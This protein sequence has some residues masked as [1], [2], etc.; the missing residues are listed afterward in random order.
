MSRKDSKLARIT[1]LLE[2]ESKER[3]FVISELKSVHLESQRLQNENSK[4]LA[5]INHQET[6]L[7]NKI[8]ILLTEKEN[9]ERI[10][11]QF[12]K[13]NAILDKMVFNSKES[14]NREG[15][16]YN[17]NSHPKREVQTPKTPKVTNPKSSLTKCLYC[18][19][20]GHT[21]LYCK[22]KEDESKGKYKW[23]PK[24]EKPKKDKETKVAQK[25]PNMVKNIVKQPK[26]HYH[27]R[28]IGFQQRNIKIQASTSTNNTRHS[29][30]PKQGY[31]ARN[32]NGHGYTRNDNAY[33]MPRNTSHN[34]GRSSQ[35]GND[36]RNS[37]VRNNMN[38]L[39]ND[40]S[41]DSIITIFPRSNNNHA[42]GNSKYM[43]RRNPYHISNRNQTSRNNIFF[44]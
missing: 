14:F 19:V 23:I 16:G 42:S 36:S 1:S 11:R 3:E 20:S 8:N 6:F 5:Q 35:Y 27:Q 37:Y 41:R 32:P 4:I 26:F 22:A 9:L 33:S 39:A 10:V 29:N 25:K 21:R 38:Y 13:S 28:S 40:H 18:N 31:N 12:T 44:M 30:V 34:N 24:G 15:L 2:T 43:P 7:N 17:A